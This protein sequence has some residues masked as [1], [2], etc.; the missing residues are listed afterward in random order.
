VVAQPHFPAR[1][2]SFSAAVSGRASIYACSG[3]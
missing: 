1:E 3:L 2:L